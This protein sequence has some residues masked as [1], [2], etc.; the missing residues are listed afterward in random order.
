MAPR[1][2][3][4]LR[5]SQIDGDSTAVVDCKDKK[6]RERAYERILWVRG[7]GTYLKA[8]HVYFGGHTD[9]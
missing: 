2:T 6:K 4:S 8:D 5:R 9:D 7:L 1:D 3:E